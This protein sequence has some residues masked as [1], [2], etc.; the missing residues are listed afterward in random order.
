MIKIIVEP[1]N[2]YIIVLI[3]AIQIISSTCLN[4]QVNH[5]DIARNHA[6]TLSGITHTI[7]NITGFCVPYVAG[8]FLSEGVYNKII[9]ALSVSKI[10]FYTL[11]KMFDELVYFLTFSCSSEHVGKLAVCIFHRCSCVHNWCY[12]LCDICIRIRT[13]MEPRLHISS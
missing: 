2:Y 12:L 4:V 5:V 6:A 7:A 10:W 3:H 13:A 9:D 8:I 1:K 11:I